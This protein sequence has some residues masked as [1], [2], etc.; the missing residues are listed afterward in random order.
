MVKEAAAVAARLAEIEN[1][2]QGQIIWLD[3]LARL[4]DSSKF[5]GPEKAIADSLLMTSK[6]TGG[7]SVVMPLHITE[8]A[9]NNWGPTIKPL[10]DDTHG[11]QD[12]NFKEDPR[13]RDYPWSLTQI[14]TITAD[15]ATQEK[16]GKRQRSSRSPSSQP[17]GR[18]R[19]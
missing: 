9:S 13:N 8:K 4:S 6:A 19:N 14:V 1:F 18:T 10:H 2:T 3:E 5:P 7:G 17:R 11:I 15:P 16:A 12:R